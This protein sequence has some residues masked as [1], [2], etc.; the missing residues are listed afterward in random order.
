MK[1][2]KAFSKSII[3]NNPC[4]CVTESSVLVY[5]KLIDLTIKLPI[6]FQNTLKNSVVKPWFKPEIDHDVS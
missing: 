2:S 5:P 3:S 6:C 1:Q 4:F